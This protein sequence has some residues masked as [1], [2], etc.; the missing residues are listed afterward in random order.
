MFKRKTFLILFLAL[1]IFSLPRFS[2]AKDQIKLESSAAISET[3][4]IE[5]LISNDNP[6]DLKLKVE[7]G[8]YDPNPEKAKLD[9][10]S[11]TFSFQEENYGYGTATLTAL[12]KGVT[13]QYRL[14]DTTDILDPSDIYYFT[15][16][17]GAV[18]VSSPFFPG[19]Q[20]VST[21][22]FVVSNVSSTIANLH[23]IDL[24]PGEHYLFKTNTFSGELR[25]EVIADSIGSAS[26]SISLLTPGTTYTINLFGYEPDT[27]PD[28]KINTERIYDIGTQTVKFRTLAEVVAKPD[29]V[30]L[31]TPD[32]PTKTNTSS[33]SSTTP[34]GSGVEG[35]LVKCTDNC[36]FNDFLKLISRVVKFILFDLAVPIAAIMFFYAGFLMVTSGDE[37]AG[38]RTKAKNI[39][40]NTLIGLALAAGAWVI[41]HT[42]L[43]ILGYSGSWIGF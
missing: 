27:N 32:T 36:D 7:Y 11:N 42:L 34:P 17:A 8:E 33:S 19:Q 20:P 29:P 14:F 28:P 40:T 43:S 35:G 12:R 4:L 22:I 9:L 18:Y 26:G 16:T 5:V 13:Y 25:T 24:I 1:A 2:F 23:A 37:S 15:T 39:F 30:T 31:G 38:A 3:G 21:P 10:K 6:Q 41:I